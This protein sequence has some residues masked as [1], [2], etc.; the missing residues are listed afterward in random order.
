MISAYSPAQQ[1]VLMV[2]WDPEQTG[3]NDVVGYMLPVVHCP[4]TF[5]MKNN[6]ANKLKKVIFD[7]IS[8]P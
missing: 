5:G 2:S 6:T 8:N 4:D 3:V 1:S 7:F